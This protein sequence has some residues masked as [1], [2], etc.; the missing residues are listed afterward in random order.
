MTWVSYFVHQVAIS[1]PQ[2]PRCKVMPHLLAG[3][4]PSGLS[5]AACITLVPSF[6]L[7]LIEGNWGLSEQVIR[8]MIKW[9]RSVVCSS[10]F[11]GHIGPTPVTPKMKSSGEPRWVPGLG[12]RSYSRKSLSP[13]QPSLRLQIPKSRDFL[14]PS[15]DYKEEIS[16]KLW[17]TAFLGK[18][19]YYL[20]APLHHMAF[21]YVCE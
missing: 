21:S 9:V 4:A 17:Q 10:W 19:M 1:Q 2:S 16:L 7:S 12:L 14:C 8:G 3:D 13:A 18:N 6:L 11:D 15:G 20:L 5:S